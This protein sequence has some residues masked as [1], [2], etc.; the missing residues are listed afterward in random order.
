MQPKQLR[1]RCFIIAVVQRCLAW[2]RVSERVA[3]QLTGHMTRSVFDR[4]NIVSESDLRAGVDRL[5]AYVKK[6][7]KETIVEPLK[8]AGKGQA[9]K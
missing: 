5:A 1:I 2:H 3:M 7:P 4:Y 8:K 6:L 9:S